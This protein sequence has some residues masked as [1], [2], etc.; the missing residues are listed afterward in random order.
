MI[1]EIMAQTIFGRWH[2]DSRSD[3]AADCH[4]RSCSVAV[5]PDLT[6]S[7]LLKHRDFTN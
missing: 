7:Q 3:P 6:S 4:V 5:S 2:C 1:V